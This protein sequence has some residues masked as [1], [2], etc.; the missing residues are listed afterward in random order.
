MGINPDQELLTGS[1]GTLRLVPE[2]GLVPAGRL[3]G[4]SS[5]SPQTCTGV[6]GHQTDG[7]S[8]E[9]P[10]GAAQAHRGHIVLQVFRR[11]Y[12]SPANPQQVIYGRRGAILQADVRLLP[13]GGHKT[14][15][16]KG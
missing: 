7:S 11:S 3:G 1:G 12:C 5:T 16:L 10:A 4:R 9:T 13:Q 2:E 15:P 8:G 14:I 6:K